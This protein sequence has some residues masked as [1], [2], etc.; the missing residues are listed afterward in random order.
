MEIKEILSTLLSLVMHQKPM[1]DK[2]RDKIFAIFHLPWQI[3]KQT[4]KIKKSMNQIE[5]Y[6]I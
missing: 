4:Y 1:K 5:C 2:I 6:F 3:N